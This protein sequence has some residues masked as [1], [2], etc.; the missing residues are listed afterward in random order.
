M[1]DNARRA[2]LHNK[3]KQIEESISSENQIPS[4]GHGNRMV[5]HIPE[6]LSSDGV[7]RDAEESVVAIGF[8]SP[9][10]IEHM[11][12]MV[13]SSDFIDR[14]LANVWQLMVDMAESKDGVSS[15]KLMSEC[16]SRGYIQE[17][18]GKDAFGKILSRRINDAEATYY[19][20]AVARFSEIRTIE[21]ATMQLRESIKDVNADPLK[22][23]Q[24][25]QARTQGIGHS[26]D[27]GFSNMPDIVDAIIAD[28]ELPEEERV[29]P[30][31]TGITTLDSVIGGF[32]AGKLYLLGGRT[33]KGKSAMAGNFMVSAVAQEK[34]VW[35]VTLEMTKKDLAERTLAYSL[36][37]DLSRFKK[38][39]SNEEIRAIRLL[40][41]SQRGVVENWVTECQESY[42]T[43]KAKAKLRKSSKKGLDLLIVDNLQLVRPE[44]RS[45]S[46]AERL[47]HLTEDFKM[48]AKELDI[49]VLVLCQLS[50]D[51]EGNDGTIT[52]WA[53]CRTI[54]NDADAAMI[55]SWSSKQVVNDQD[56]KLTIHKMRDG[57]G[58]VAIDLA[59]IGKY[60]AFEE[61]VTR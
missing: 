3:R 32:C 43:I 40:N 51:A 39:L 59:F 1:S 6:K 50:A 49:A 21:Y 23:L 7:I 15:N 56:S 4:Y 17:L 38:K 46:E 20:R 28:H 12:S 60:Q 30:I 22:I 26:K 37:I 47:K 35:F 33:G 48:L 57:I 25:F 29:R 10:A 53:G 16:L 24:A 41:D 42:R 55:L 14:A 45:E 18:G 61:R 36:E 13:S 11:A 58:S 8:V 9:H 27:A 2:A 31:S 44:S 19:S 34:S 54:A 52:N 5:S